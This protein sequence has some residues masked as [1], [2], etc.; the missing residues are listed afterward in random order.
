MCMIGPMTALSTDSSAS[1]DTLLTPSTGSILLNPCL[2]DTMISRLPALAG[3]IASG[4]VGVSTGG[5]AAVSGAGTAATGSAGVGGPAGATIPAG[6]TGVT[7]WAGKSV[8]VKDAANA[9]VS[10][11]KSGPFATRRVLG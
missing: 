1:N 6:G 8:A 3:A 7:I 9:A 5:G 10:I 11:I 4:L 2:P